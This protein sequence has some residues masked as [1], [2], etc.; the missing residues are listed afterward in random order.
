V[1]KYVAYRRQKGHTGKATFAWI[2]IARCHCM[3][4]KT[5]F[6]VDWS[7]LFCHKST[8]AL[9]S[10]PTTPDPIFEVVSNNALSGEPGNRAK[11]SQGL[12]KRKKTVKVTHNAIST[13]SPSSREKILSSVLARCRAREIWKISG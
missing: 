8:E 2:M 13:I 10:E 7:A 9:P 1:L 11:A 3:A 5:G 6:E 4:T 12:P